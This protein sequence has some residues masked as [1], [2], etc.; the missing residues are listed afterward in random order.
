M[1]NRIFF[2]AL[3]AVLFG[4]L[5]TAATVS[6]PL[7]ANGRNVELLAGTVI[8]LELVNNVNP[9]TTQVGNIIQLKVRSNVYAD[10]RVAIRSNMMA[11]GRVTEVTR[12]TAT[13]SGIV[14][15]EVRDVQAVDGQMINLNAT[16]QY[17]PQGDPGM[18]GSADMGFILTAHVMDNITIRVN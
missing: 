17:S 10:G 14:K 2:A 12:P 1:K 13:S 8:Y 3:F 4:H 11:L 7:P 5:A 9:G 15:I 6:H 16:Y 18:T